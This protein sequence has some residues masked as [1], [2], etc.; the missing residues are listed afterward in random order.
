MKG[1]L[2]GVEVKIGELRAAN[3]VNLMWFAPHSTVVFQL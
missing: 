3:L 2:M 1:H